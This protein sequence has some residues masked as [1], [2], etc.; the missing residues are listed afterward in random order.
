MPYPIAKLAYGLRSRLNEL[1]TPAERY[2]LQEA[3]GDMSIC[4]PNLQPIRKKY[5][6][7]LDIMGLAPNT[8]IADIL[9]S[10]KQ[11]LSLLSIDVCSDA[12][13]NNAIEKIVDFMK[14]QNENFSLYINFDRLYHTDSWEDKTD[15]IVKKLCED[16]PHRLSHASGAFYVPKA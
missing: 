2:R 12:L 14:A 13:E 1:V 6:I 11:K 7:E 10:Q 3:A 16:L 5:G 8:W 15:E 4:P 9:K